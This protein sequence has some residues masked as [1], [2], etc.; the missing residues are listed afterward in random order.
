MT[1]REPL[2]SSVSGIARAPFARNMPVGVA[3][4]TLFPAGIAETVWSG[5]T[6]KEMEARDARCRRAGRCW[7]VVGPGNLPK[8][9][10]KEMEIPAKRS[11][12]CGGLLAAGSHR[13]GCCDV[14]A[15]RRR[16]TPAPWQWRGFWNWL[17]REK[18]VPEL[19]PCRP[20]ALTVSYFPSRCRFRRLSF[21]CIARCGVLP[22]PGPIACAL[23]FS[24]SSPA[25]GYAVPW[26]T[27]SP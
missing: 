2:N 11:P 27:L 12:R 10:V 19:G 5:R 24:V 1:F 4:A 15:G 6:P 13:E 22:V 17:R 25:S 16:L 3:G 9:D 20:W 21:V 18:R 7:R 23:Y 26:R 8:S 14:D